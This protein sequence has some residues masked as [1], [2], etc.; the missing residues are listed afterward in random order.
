[1]KLQCRIAKY[2]N[3]LSERAEWLG[4]LYTDEIKNAHIAHIHIQYINE[5][6]GH[7][8]FANQHL[9]VGSFVG[10]YTGI[11]RHRS[12]FCKRSK[13]Y[14]FAYPH[15]K[16]GLRRFTIDAE[17]QGNETRYINHS[18]HPN[19]EAISAYCGGIFYVIIRTTQKVLTGQQLLLN[20]GGEYWRNRHPS[21]EIAETKGS[22]T[23]EVAKCL[24]KSGR[25]TLGVLAMELS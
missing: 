9:P 2:F 15:I 10:I 5:Y 22:A 6:I 21:V 8:V 7:G 11:V 25:F 12:L 16:F 17:D 24:E 20:Y 23:D 1:M 13:K 18:Y 19:C 4:E 3:Y 14:S